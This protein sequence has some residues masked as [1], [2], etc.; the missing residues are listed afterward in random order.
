[1]SISL[2]KIDML[3]ERTQV[4]YKE[5]KEALERHDGDMVE[6]LIDLE[7][8]EATLDLKKEKKRK[9]GAHRSGEGSRHNHRETCSKATHQAKNLF[10]HVHETNFI[11]M[12]KEKKMLDIP[13]TFAILI[14]LL[15]LPFSL[16]V[17]LAA[18][19][20]GYEIQIESPDGSQT[21]ISA[22]ELSDPESDASE[23]IH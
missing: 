17:L 3:M 7:S 4:G 10:K 15:T 14:I 18:Y 2:E 22:S 23:E 9:K 5:A 6:A 16:F 1:M 11:L 8:R 20:F 19:F 12:G 13:A 21:H